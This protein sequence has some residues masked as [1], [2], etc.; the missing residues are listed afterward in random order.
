MNGQEQETEF[1]GKDLEPN[2]C[3]RWEGGDLLQTFLAKYFCCVYD[4]EKLLG[5][6]IETGV[7]TE[8]GKDI[9]VDLRFAQ[10]GP[11]GSGADRM[12]RAMVLI[13][14]HAQI[15]IKENSVDLS[16]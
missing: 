9:V 14:Y 8:S 12:C 11:L 10:G 7:D 15:I 16:F 4:G 13:Q 1:W 3:N 6:Q 5:S 2:K